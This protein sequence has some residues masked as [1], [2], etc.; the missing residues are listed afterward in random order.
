VEALRDRGEIAE[1]QSAASGWRLVDPLLA[2]WVNEGR[3]G[4]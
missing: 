3:P 2:T 4:L 1:D